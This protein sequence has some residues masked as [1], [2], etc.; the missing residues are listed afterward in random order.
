M[1]D[2]KDMRILDMLRENSRAPL[3]TIAREFGVSETAVKKRIEKLK[4]KGVIRKY[5][6]EINEKVI[7]CAKSVACLDVANCEEAIAFIKTLPFVSSVFLASGSHNLIVEIEG[8]EGVIPRVF[9]RLKKAKFV[10]KAC[11]STLV[12]RV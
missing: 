2:E 4:K 12:R 6:V 10:K 5:T 7:G 11:N 1:L 3:K 9:E 8:P